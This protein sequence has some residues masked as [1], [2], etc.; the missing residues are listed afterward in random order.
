MERNHNRWPTVSIILINFNGIKY[1]KPCIESL[2]KLDY[3]R[4]QVEI[5]VVDN[6]ST[7]DRSIEILEKMNDIKLIKCS[8]NMG[9]AKANNIG[10]ENSTG[11]YIAIL[12]NDTFVDRKWLKSLV[13]ALQRDSNIG[14]VM[15]K[16]YN[17]YEKAKYW[18]D[19][20]GTL[21]LGGFFAWNRRVSKE[22]KENVELFFASGCS[23]L[24][25][26]DLVDKPFDDD[27]FIY[28]E[29]TY[30]S[31][32]ARLKGYTIKMVP[33]SI[34]YHEGGAVTKDITEMS[35]FFTYLGERNRIINYLIFFSL[36]NLVRVFPIMIATVFFSNVY[37]VKRAHIRLKSYFWIL[38]HLLRIL[39]KRRFAQS[40]RKIGD[41]EIIKA[42]SY[43]LFEEEQ[44]KNK[45]FK[46]VIV[47]LN[48]ASYSYCKLVGLKTAEMAN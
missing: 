6:G 16:I 15:S 39:K 1:T 31:W 2:R 41:K 37:D 5:I 3:P 44:V 38:I 43:K 32:L 25:K 10:V 21:T 9:F 20:Y 23:L 47:F 19:G 24:Y 8:K 40:K 4:S 33:S 12:N 34:V 45:I 35:N 22:T 11:E 27:Y 14:V 28:A 48:K 29:D 18:F 42:M 26:K 36:G 46:A 17:K 30:L 13:K 7:K